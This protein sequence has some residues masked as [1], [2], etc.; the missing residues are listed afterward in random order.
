MKSRKLSAP[1]A[2]A[3]LLCAPVLA[4][5]PPAAETA[6]AAAT[7]ESPIDSAT[8]LKIGKELRKRSD[9][10]D[11]AATFG[12][13][14]LIVAIRTGQVSL[15]PDDAKEFGKLVGYSTLSS[16]LVK[17]AEQGHPPAID[18]VCKMGED[19]LAPQYMRDE[20]AAKCAV[21]RAKFPAKD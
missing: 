9:D 1:F 2:I 8:A 20:G 3:A 16:W 17:S 6:P 18:A 11:G 5:D 13:W 4:A 21:L 7:R 19:P 10:G 15:E 12:L 14:S